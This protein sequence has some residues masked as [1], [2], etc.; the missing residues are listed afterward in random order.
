MINNIQ[1]FMK[2]KETQTDYANITRP[3][4]EKIKILEEKKTQT[5]KEITKKFDGLIALESRK[6]LTWCSKEPYCNH[7]LTV[8]ATV[9]TG[10]YFDKPQ[11]ICY[12]LCCNKLCKNKDSIKISG[13]LNEEEFMTSIDQIEEML[14]IISYDDP[15]ASLESIKDAIREELNNKKR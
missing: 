10:D 2:A 4:I 11:E 9:I 5:I 14:K 6:M 8:S 1:D 12:C 13:E 7:D 3:Y 15:N